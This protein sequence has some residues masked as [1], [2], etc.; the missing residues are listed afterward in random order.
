MSEIVMNISEERQQAYYLQ[1]IVL[2]FN[3]Q[4]TGSNE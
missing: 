1:D 3:F 2:R 4:T